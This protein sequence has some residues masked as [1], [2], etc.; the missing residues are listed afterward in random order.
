[1]YKDGRGVGGGFRISPALKASLV[2]VTRVRLA[3]GA[4]RLG[5]S[6]PKAPLPGPRVQLAKAE[7]E[8]ARV[9]PP[10]EPGCPPSPAG[11]ALA[12]LDKGAGFLSLHPVGLGCP[13][14]A[15]GKEPACR[16]RRC[17]KIPW[18]C[19]RSP[20]GGHGNPLQYSCLEKPMDRGA[21]RAPG[22]HTELDTLK[23][24]STDASSMRFQTSGCPW[25]RGGSE[26]ESSSVMTP[27]TIQPMEFSRPEYWSGEPFPSPGD[28]PNPG[29]EPRSPALQADSLPA[30]PAGKPQKFEMETGGAAPASRPAA[31]CFGLLS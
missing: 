6:A 26:S 24:L 8:P 13:G 31:V 14:G 21:W 12:P 4:D 11:R 1:M 18:R 17:E 9:R 2:L 16:C 19:G 7:R 5:S 22:G 25:S 23:R 28:P 10:A 3:P 27:R 15:G 29:I 30:E 20:G